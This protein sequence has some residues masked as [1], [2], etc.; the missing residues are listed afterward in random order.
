[1]EVSGS[2]EV[3]GV[4]RV[5]Q[6][7]HRVPGQVAEPPQGLPSQGAV[8]LPVEDERRGLQGK[9]GA[10]VLRPP[11]PD[12]PA[13]PL[14]N[15]P[16]TP[17]SPS[18]LGGGGGGRASSKRDPSPLPPM[19]GSQD[20]VTLLAVPSRPRTAPECSSGWRWVRWA[21]SRAAE[22][23]PASARAG[24]SG[25]SAR[26]SP[27]PRA[28]PPGPAARAPAAP[29]ALPRCWPPGRAPSSQ[30]LGGRGTR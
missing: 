10:V 24:R 3:A 1:M 27:A 17:S 21:R 5:A 16:Q 23:G 11:G 13:I 9:A 26:G 29:P 4:P 15:P 28:A 7:H 2:V 18:R 30:N 25:R 20:W 14:G 22:G 12:P 19:T 8:Q 6:L